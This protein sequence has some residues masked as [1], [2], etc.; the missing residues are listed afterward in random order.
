MASPQRAPAPARPPSW[1]APLMT[2]MGAC[3][4]GGFLF[5]I[6]LLTGSKINLDEPV[7]YIL[8]VICGF[9]GWRLGKSVR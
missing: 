6:A 9:A 2:F 3:T 5:L 8:A 1:L 4:P 7:W